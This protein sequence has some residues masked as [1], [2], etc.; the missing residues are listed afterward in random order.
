[1]DHRVHLITEYGGNSFFAMCDC[2]WVGRKQTKAIRAAE[3][4]STHIADLYGV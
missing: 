2:G 1:M 4:Y 3:T